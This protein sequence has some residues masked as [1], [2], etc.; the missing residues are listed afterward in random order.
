MTRIAQL[1]AS[2]SG[3]ERRVYCMI[4][5][6]EPIFWAR[7]NRAMPWDGYYRSGLECLI[8]PETEWSTGLDLASKE[9]DASAITISLDD[10]P[11]ADNPQLSYFGRL[12]APARWRDQAYA[13]LSKATETGSVV[14]ATD[15]TIY[16]D[17]SLSL[18]DASGEA[19]IGNETFSYTARASDTVAWEPSRWSFTGVTRGLYPCIG[20]RWARTIGLPASA[21]A[22]ESA[23]VLI[24]AVP[25]TWLGRRIALYVTAY[26]PSTGQYLSQR[27]SLLLWAGNIS[28][29]VSYDPNDRKWQLVCENALNQTKRKLFG[30]LPTAKVCGINLTNQ[31]AAR[32]RLYMHATSSDN[33]NIAAGTYHRD[34]S[35]APGWY[36]SA[37]EIVKVIRADIIADTTG[38]WYRDEYNLT[39]NNPTVY[40]SVE[41]N[42]DEATAS[43]QFVV[44]PTIE[45]PDPD[46]SGYR[47]GVGPVNPGEAESNF[48][49]FSH[50]AQALGFD[51]GSIKWINYNGASEGTPTDLRGD[52]V[53]AAYHPNSYAASGGYLYVIDDELVALTQGDALTGATDCGWLFADKKVESRGAEKATIIGVTERATVTGLTPDQNA[54]LGG[55]TLHKLT[56]AP[57][58]GSIRGIDYS[59][60]SPWSSR[61][62]TEIPSKN[63]A[64]EL[65]T[66][67]QAYGADTGR[68]LQR[69]PFQLLLN[70][71][72]STGTLNYNGDYDVLPVEMGLAVQRD[73]VDE[74]SFVDA[75]AMAIALSSDLSR[76]AFAAAKPQ[77][78]LELFQREAQIYGTA[79]IWSDG[80]LRVSQL[81]SQRF[82]T[83][84]DTINDSNSAVLIDR[85]SVT[86][87]ADTVINAWEIEAVN[88]LTE[89]KTIIRLNDI[90]SI[91][92]MS[93]EAQVVDIRHDG[94][95]ATLGSQ[96]GQI[97]GEKAFARAATVSRFPWWVVR[98][99]LSPAMMGRVFIGDIVRLQSAHIPDPNG[100]GEMGVDAL[101]LVLDRTQSFTDFTGTCTLYIYAGFDENSRRP[102]APSALIDR[103]A[104]S[105]GW[106]STN[107]YLTLVPRAYGA[108]ADAKDGYR[109]TSGDVVMITERA[110]AVR[111]APQS[112]SGLIVL[113]DFEIN[114]DNILALTGA[115]SLPGFNT[116]GTVEYVVLPDLYTAVTAE[117]QA[118]SAW[119]ADDADKLV[120]GDRPQRFG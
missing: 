12:F 87:S 8:P 103:T 67:T 89:E 112:W 77:S 78:W 69:G 11:D 119:L 60:G 49:G 97:L 72:V 52:A 85:P 80:K 56:V 39:T 75:D 29:E 42:P 13:F 48:S 34:V 61:I 120:D 20:R 14:Y 111:S 117:Q 55:A 57:P 114:G 37:E 74:Q 105:A 94:L 66:L 38:T 65:P 51:G 62:S 71:L 106:D 28:T 31:S 7:S 18:F 109:F 110:P 95:D 92:G 15:T 4:D 10:I 9:T 88:Q 108:S 47:Y 101:A 21:D 53:A 40:V 16:A 118:A 6:I 27:D 99:T 36:A 1:L 32:L 54:A 102:W 86:M 30:N 41:Y 59:L 17:S 43:F 35:I 44:Y 24:S 23:R 90:E 25:Y 100:S 79:L 22:A 84:T 76:R 68:A 26:D 5:G 46:H 82:D 115:A 96:L 91:A 33:P 83:T 113:G 50:L 107:K 73:L 116:G 104:T 81:Y 64:L 70:M 58:Q 2:D 63:K 19:H 45:H 93:R 98:R 3:V